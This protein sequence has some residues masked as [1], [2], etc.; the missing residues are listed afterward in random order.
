MTDTRKLYVLWAL[1][2]GATDRA[3]E[4]PLTSFPLTYAEALRVISKARVD[5]WHGF[6][7]ARESGGV[8]NFARAATA[9]DS[10]RERVS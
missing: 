9:R 2:R 8:P 3:E 10:G 1:P 6:Q 4:R 7:L 5:G